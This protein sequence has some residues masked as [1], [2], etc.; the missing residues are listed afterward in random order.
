MKALLGILFI[1]IVV[2][3]WFKSIEFKPDE[4][5][6]ENTEKNNKW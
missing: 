1:G 2:Y 3:L 5:E 6:Q 4:I